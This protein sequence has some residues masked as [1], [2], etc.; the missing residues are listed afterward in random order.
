LMQRVGADALI[1]VLFVSVIA[2]LAAVWWEKRQA[3]RQLHCL[4]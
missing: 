1:A 3:R 4:R 2:F